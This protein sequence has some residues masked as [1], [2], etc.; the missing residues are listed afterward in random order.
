MDTEIKKKLERTLAQYWKDKQKLYYLYSSLEKIENE[1]KVMLGILKDKED[2]L[3]SPAPVQLSFTPGAPVGYCEFTSV[4]RSLEMYN[5]QQQKIREKIDRLLERKAKIRWRIIQKEHSAGW[6]KHVAENFL[7]QEE[8]TIF[9]QCYG[10]GRSNIQVAIALDYEETTI[11]RK[12]EKI[13]G[14]FYQFLRLK[15]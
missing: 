4:E 8:R 2:L 11:R 6:I 1:I 15:A 3:P 9:E 13:L 10:Y 14:V 12:R 7:N 5:L